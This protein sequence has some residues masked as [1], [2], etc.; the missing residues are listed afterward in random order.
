MGSKLS[1]AASLPNDGFGATAKLCKAHYLRKAAIALS[2]V[3]SPHRPVP[4]K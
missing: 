1:L 2:L 3:Q 4:E